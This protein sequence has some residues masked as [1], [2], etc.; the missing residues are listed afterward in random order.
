MKQSLFDLVQSTLG[1]NVF[2]GKKVLEVGPARF[3]DSIA[4][5]D[6][7]ADVTALDIRRHQ[8]PPEHIKFV[9][10]DFLSWQTED[11]FDIAYLS[12][13]ALF[14]PANDVFK[15]LEQ[16]KPKIIAVRTMYDYPEPNWTAEELKQLYFTVPTDWSNYFE[17]L[18]YAT[19]YS[20]K[21]ELETPDMRGRMRLFR[22]TDYIGEKL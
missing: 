22:Y 6:S 17:P 5:R 19:V 20:R 13:V 11:R 18:G 7:G 8:D 3:S 21:Y 12:N 15:K 16:L 9:E 1:A 10:S 14:M 2:R 4:L